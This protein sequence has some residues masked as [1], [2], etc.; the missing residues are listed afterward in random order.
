MKKLL[1]APGYIII[2]FVYFF[3]TE[4]GK[5]RNVTLGSRWWNYKDALAPI[6]SVCLYFFIAIKLLFPDTEV[7][8]VSAPKQLEHSAYTPAEGNTPLPMHDIPRQTSI[9]KSEAFP[10]PVL[11][12]D[13]SVIT[14]QAVDSNSKLSE[15]ENV[16][17]ADENIRT[18]TKSNI[19]HIPGH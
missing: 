15:W 16:E 19:Q 1:W 17:I 18:P 7:K 3:P 6:F 2:A 13:K 8:T 10:E 12:I 9:I 5:K 14:T 11:P 4:W